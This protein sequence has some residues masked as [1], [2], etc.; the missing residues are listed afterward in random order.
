MKVITPLIS[1]YLASSNAYSTTAMFYETCGNGGSRFWQVVGHRWI[2]DPAGASRV[3]LK[4]RTILQ[5]E[6][7]STFHPFLFPSISK[8][9]IRH[10]GRYSLRLPLQYVYY[11]RSRK[12]A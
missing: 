4:I 6:M 11:F 10:L 7:L 12:T 2:I 8:C 1:F 5:L 9:R 3:N